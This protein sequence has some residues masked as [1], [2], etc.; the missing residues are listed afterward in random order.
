ME[1][2]AFK[3]KLLP[4]FESEYRKRHDEL[5]PE[6]RALLKEAGVREYSIFLDM[7]THELI[8]I[9]KVTNRDAHEKLPDHPVMRRWW[10]FMKDIM[11]TNPDN[12]PVSVP[13][14]E[15]FYLP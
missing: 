15:V 6:L 13:L 3:M 7:S 1:R 10:A 14:Q 4:G 5:W 12:S 8:G 11:V 2:V 9:L